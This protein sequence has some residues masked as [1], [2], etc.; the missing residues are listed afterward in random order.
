TT[1]AMNAMRNPRAHDICFIDRSPWRMAAREIEK[2]K[3]T[4]A[5]DASPNPKRTVFHALAV[6]A[7]ARLAVP[8]Q[9]RDRRFHLIPFCSGG[10]LLDGFGARPSLMCCLYG[11][12]LVLR[13]P[14]RL[15]L[16]ERLL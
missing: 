2:R 7:V 13:L 5:T 8:V 4:R 15:G 1:P 10:V 11:V 6:R 14:E 16:G 12:R 9:Q 3:A